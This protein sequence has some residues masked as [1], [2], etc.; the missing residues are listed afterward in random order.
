MVDLPFKSNALV[1]FIAPVAGYFEA[2]KSSMEDL[3]KLKLHTYLQP[4]VMRFISSKVFLKSSDTD[5]MELAYNMSTKRRVEPQTNTELQVLALWK[6]H[7]KVYQVIDIDDNFFD[8]G[9][10]SLKAG[11]LVS[12]MRKFFDV[13]KLN[14]GDLLNEPTIRSI[15]AR[16][17][18]LNSTMRISLT[19]ELYQYKIVIV[20]PSFNIFL[21]CI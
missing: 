9:G 15:S 8:L 14:V 4:S 10:D 2:P 18:E 21:K 5:F 3:C 20:R 19:G 11:Q 12:A 17:D 1:T 6:S 7:L 13:H 16:I